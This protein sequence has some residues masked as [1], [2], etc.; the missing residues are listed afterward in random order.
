MSNYGDFAFVYD[1][2]TSEIDYEKRAEYFDRVILRHGGFHGILLDLG[3]GTGKLS[4]ALSGLGYDVVG[5]DNSAEMLSAALEKKLKSGRD[6]IYLCQ[7]MTELDLY[8]TV[9]T[10]VSALDSLNHLTDYGDFCTALQ[11]V[12]LF[13]HPDGVFVFDVNTCYKHREVLANNTF[14]YDYDDVYCA[15]QNSLGEN[16]VVQMDLDIFVSEDGERYL[17]MEDHFAER[18]Y[19]EKQ[20]EEALRMAGLQIQAVYGEDSL[21]PP[22]EDEQRLVYVVKHA[23]NDKGGFIV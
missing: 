18:A 6:I 14:V 3:C 15:W 23:K 2:L 9:D 20:I 1:R 13:L 5:V 4:E 8:G 10:V 11:K 16:D 21:Q 17:R 22:Q 12:S 7:D 19:S